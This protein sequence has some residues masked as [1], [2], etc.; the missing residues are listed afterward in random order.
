MSAYTSQQQDRQVDWLVAL[1]VVVSWALVF[2]LVLAVR[3]GGAA[4]VMW[5]DDVALLLTA[6][7]AAAVAALAARRAWGSRRGLAWAFIATGLLMNAFGEAAWAVQELALGKEDVFPSVADAGYLGL[8]LPVF[9]GLLLMPQA[10]ATGLRR[11]KMTFD[12]LIGLGAVAA[13]SS[14]LVVDSVLR[15]SG[16][17]VLER[18]IGLAYPL[19]DIGVVFAVLVLLVRAG[20]SAGAGSLVFLAL[21]FGSIAFSDSLYTYLTYSGDYASG[22]YI[23]AGWIGGYGLV[24]LA[25]AM[26]AY[27]EAGMEA[28]VAEKE[29]PAFAWQPLAMYAPVALMGAAL[30]GDHA[31]RDG[32]L[33]VVFLLIVGL[34]FLRQFIAHQ[35][36]VSL[37][38]RLAAATVQLEQK[39][40]SQSLEL[41]KRRGGAA[42]EEKAPGEH[43]P[44]VL[45][46]DWMT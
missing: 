17:T 37:N 21:G 4:G 42:G 11:L 27:R 24:T 43:A 12:V 18:G 31:L 9:V 2:L 22:S 29:E 35:E 6:L 14:V 33:F 5:F 45:A 32:V 25:A 10:P 19:A 1:T 38:H 20:R 30:L 34:M 23:D 8:Y 28:A 13:V 40:R 16:A 36:N 41:W 7:A 44:P 15:D 39:V 3:P 26:S 46:Q